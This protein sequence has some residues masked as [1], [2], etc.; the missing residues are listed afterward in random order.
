MK[1]N[2]LLK[3][4]P[5]LFLMFAIFSNLTSCKKADDQLYSCNKEVNSW[6]V[7]NKSE[8]VNLS[9]EQLVTLPLAY[10][11][12]IFIA[13]PKER[14]C[15]L[16]KEKLDLLLN[17][18][19]F[20][21]NYKRK[22][23]E[24]LSFLTP[25]IYDHKSNEKPANYVSE[26]LDQWENEILTNYELDT[27]LYSINFCTFMTKKELDY[28]VNNYKNIDYSWLKGGDKLLIPN[29]AAGGTCTC[30][31][32]IYCSLFLTVDCEEGLNHCTISWNCGLLGDSK[33]TG[34]CDSGE[35]VQPPQP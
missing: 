8:V 30:R 20:D 14:K 22:I 17:S 25:N 26:Y 27:T 6:V 13:M 11:K 9:R 32:D 4:L 2:H 5:N 35:S 12:A 1:T 7:A 10:Q 23:E 3:F 34:M 24:L 29:L 19:E 18:K 15:E 31:Y 21:T 28:Y 33:C 16:Y